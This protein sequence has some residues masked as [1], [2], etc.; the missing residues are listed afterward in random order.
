[1]LWLNEARHEGWEVQM[2]NLRAP[3][4]SGGNGR[5]NGKEAA[6]GLMWHYSCVAILCGIPG[7]RDRRGLG[8]LAEEEEEVMGD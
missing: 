5:G 4:A 3:A 2:V 1:V 6:G 7:W 8:S